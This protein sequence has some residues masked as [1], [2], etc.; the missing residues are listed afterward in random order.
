MVSR[1]LLTVLCLLSAALSAA[2]QQAG[3][4][5]DFPFMVET[6]PFLTLSNPALLDRFDGQVSQ[7]QSHFRKEN[8]GWLSPTESP[9]SWDAGASAQSYRRIGPNLTFFGSLGWQHFTGKD[10]GGQILLDYTYNPVNFLESGDDTKGTKKRERYALSGGMSYRL[11][12]RWAIGVQLNYTSADQTKTKDPRFSN[13]WMDLDLKAGASLK[14]SDRWV[15]GVAF[16]FRNTLEQV[17]GG[18][19]GT[20]DQQYFI[21]TDKGCYMGT[22]S[23]LAGDYNPISVVNPRP[24]M[25]YFWGASLQAVLDGRFANELVFQIR[26]GYYGRR[27]STTATFFEFNGIRA[28]YKGK[29]L[30]PSGR[31]L[32]VLSLEAGLETLTNLENKFRYVTP[33]GQNTVVEYTGQ[34]RILDRLMAAATLSYA[35]YK[36]ADEGRPGLSLGARLD[37]RVRNQ[38]ASLYP[39]TRRQQ[40]TVLS[41]DL[42]GQKCFA[43]GPVFLDITLHALMGGG[44]GIPHEDSSAAETA[45]TSIQHFD[46]PL[47]RQYEYETALHAGAELSF[48]ISLP[49]KGAWRPYLRVSDRFVSLLSAPVYLD[50]ARRNVVIVSL[51][52]CF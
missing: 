47:F 39:F 9:D 20:T 16:L 50:G 37:G 48:G 51:G 26:N 33:T 22:V 19:Y 43:A 30:I 42:Y 34:S 4:V 7:V 45:S 40:T 15:L 1:P 49:L 10:M 52:C 44:F 38:T 6:H 28:S 24:M 23:E 2:G 21:Q 8:G 31:N 17:K 5:R 13:I 11:S 25:N 32:Q 12:R 14:A 36:D 29:L 41:A 46:T 27:S 35:W 18:I 3:T